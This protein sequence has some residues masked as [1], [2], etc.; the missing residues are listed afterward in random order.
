MAMAS[1][2]GDPV[3]TKLEESPVAAPDNMEII[4]V[5]PGDKVVSSFGIGL[6]DK[7]SRRRESNKNLCKL[8]LYSLGVLGS[9]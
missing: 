3:F 2:T 9:P 4:D 5:L 8:W 6:V 1:V 7:R